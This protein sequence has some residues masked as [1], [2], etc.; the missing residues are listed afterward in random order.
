M[1]VHVQRTAHGHLDLNVLLLVPTH[2][3]S[4][5]AYPVIDACLEVVSIRRGLR[6]ASR[7]RHQPHL[8]YP[9]RLLRTE[10]SAPDGIF[11]GNQRSLAIPLALLYIV[12]A[13]TEHNWT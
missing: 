3:A 2:A 5:Y 10:T 1:C 12:D 9:E 6:N 13:T 7:G 8:Q 4:V 11:S